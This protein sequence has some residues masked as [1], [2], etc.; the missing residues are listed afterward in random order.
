MLIGQINP[1]EALRRTPNHKAA[2]PYGVPGLVLKY[3]LPAFHEALDL[4]F[5]ALTIIGI[6]P[7]S[8]LQSHTILLYKKGDPTRLD[9]CRP[10]TLVKALYTLWTTCIVI[11]AT[12][13]I[14]SSEFLS[15]EQEGFKADRSCDR[16]ITHLGLCVVDAHSHKKDIVICYLDFKRAFL[17]TDHKQLVRVLEIMDLLPDFTRLFSN[18]YSGATT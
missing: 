7:P 1:E 12:D 11:L 2:G 4:L 6:S 16:P 9:N 17:S 5:Q 15:P 8:W 3:M 18:L 10:I 14:E 13:Y